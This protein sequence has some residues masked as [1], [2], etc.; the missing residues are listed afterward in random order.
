MTK[1]LVKNE[2]DKNLLSLKNIDIF[3]K[4]SKAFAG[5]TRVK[6]LVYLYDN[7]NITHT[8]IRKILTNMDSG[9]LSY[10][11]KWLVVAQLILY[12]KRRGLYSLSNLGLDCIDFIKRIEQR[13]QGARALNDEGIFKDID[14]PKKYIAFLK[15]T[16]RFYEANFN[17]S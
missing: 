2:W 3:S 7:H 12:D 17:E 13:Q 6:I 4:I 11:L 16:I 8:E 9:Y 10:H 1:M 5:K 15:N 14:N